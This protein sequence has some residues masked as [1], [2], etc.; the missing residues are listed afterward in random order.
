MRTEGTEQLETSEKKLEMAGSDTESEQE[1][2]SETADGGQ[3]ENVG[4]RA[5]PTETL[6]ELGHE[7]QTLLQRY[8]VT[9]YGGMAASRHGTGR[10]NFC[11]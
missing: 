9:G 7:N 2:K 10:R 4:E 6:Q 11:G 1:N 3:D 5:V 8:P